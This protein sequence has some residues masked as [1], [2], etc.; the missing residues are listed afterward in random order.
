MKAYEE[1]VEF[2]AGG[3]SVRSVADFQAS[4]EAKARVQ[5]LIRKEKNDGLTPTEKS[6]LDNY[7]TLEHIMRLVK[8]KARG[9]L[10]HG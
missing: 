1:I 2:I 8:A 3:P 9:H 6:E 7:M 4:P 5:N 10:S